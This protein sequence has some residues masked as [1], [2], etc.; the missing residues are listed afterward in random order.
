[1]EP[2]HPLAADTTCSSFFVQLYAKPFFQVLQGDA[3]VPHYV[4]KEFNEYLKCGI[5]AHGFAR[6]YC[7]ECKKDILILFANISHM[8]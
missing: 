5:L 6:A 2:L 8:L 1:M 4:Q 7:K 3:E